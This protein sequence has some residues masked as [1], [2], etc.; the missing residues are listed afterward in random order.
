VPATT[1]LSARDRLVVALDVPDAAAAA[2]FAAAVAS[3][4]GVLK[5]GLEL[6]VAEGPPVVRAAAALAPVFLDLKLYD[7]PATVERAARRAAALGARWLTVHP[8]PDGATLRAA[9]AGAGGACGILCVTLLTSIGGDAL[10]A[11]GTAGSVEEF[12]LRNAGLAAAAGCAGVVCA[13]SEA[14]AVRAACGGALEIVTPGIRPAWAA[15]KGDQA[16]VAT[17]AEAVRAGADRM[18]VGRPIR[19]AQ[20]PAA[21]ARRIV[22]EI[23]AA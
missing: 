8:G 4:A 11:A 10:R 6:F 17:P 12:V 3:E 2:R 14:A 19:D 5:V 7:I 15:D 22:A 21:A 1:K 23:A 16:R 20:D 13:A 9:V 18:V